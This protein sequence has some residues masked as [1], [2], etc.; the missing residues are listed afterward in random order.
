MLRKYFRPL[1]PHESIT[2]T[3]PVTPTDAGEI[4]I[5]TRFSSFQLKCANGVSRI[6]VT[7]EH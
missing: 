2:V 7:A 3:V 1:H 4:V 6:D 5:V